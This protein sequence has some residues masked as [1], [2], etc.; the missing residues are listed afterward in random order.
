MPRLAIAILCAALGACTGPSPARPRAE[1]IRP[2][3]PAELARLDPLVGSW[4]TR[5]E[6][7]APTR[8]E[9]EARL[10][11]AA[12]LVP[13][14]FGGAWRNE[15]VLGGMFLNSAGWRETGDGERSYYVEYLGWD[16]N[17]GKYRSWL[18]ND[19]GELSEGTLALEPDGS[20]LVQIEGLRA[21]GSATR[22]RGSMRFVDA[23]TMEWTWTE[24]GVDGTLTMRGTN[25]RAR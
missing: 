17:L 7:V 8:A 1:W 25:H 6:L 11:S 3:R 20:F 19:R 22:G 2:E 4:E 13:E 24:E 16:A 15:W 21:D 5:A 10:G 18:F 12:Q 9:L 14:S 23:D